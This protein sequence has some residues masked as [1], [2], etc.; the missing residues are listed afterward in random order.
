MLKEALRK[1]EVDIII[2]MPIFDLKEFKPV[3]RMIIARYD[4]KGHKSMIQYFQQ[5]LTILYFVKEINKV[6]GVPNRRQ[7]LAKTPTK[8][9]MEEKKKWLGLMYNKIS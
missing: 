7:D 5:T 3:L 1:V 6:F 4:K 8:M 9:R 2:S